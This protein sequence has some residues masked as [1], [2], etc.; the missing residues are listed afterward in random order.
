MIVAVLL[1]KQTQPGEDLRLRVPDLQL[2][3]STSAGE[4]ATRRSLRCVGGSV[5]SRSGCMTT[6]IAAVRPVGGWCR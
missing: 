1:V 3:Q 5:V 6:S 2:V 4:N